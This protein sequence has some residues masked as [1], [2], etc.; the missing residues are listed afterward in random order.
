LISPKEFPEKPAESAEDG[1]FVEGFGTFV[2]FSNLKLTTNLTNE[3]FLG[4]GCPGVSRLEYSRRLFIFTG[5]S[6]GLHAFVTKLRTNGDKR[7]TL[8]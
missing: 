7:F 1:T 5:L 6:Y 2:P 4:E 3:Q 8:L